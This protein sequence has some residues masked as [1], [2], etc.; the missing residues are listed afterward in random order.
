MISRSSPP[1]STMRFALITSFQFDRFHPETV[2]RLAGDSVLLGV[3]AGRV[4]DLIAANGY[5]GVVL[6]LEGMSSADGDTL[7]RVINQFARSLH[8][9]KIQPVIVA[10][11]ASDTVTYPARSVLHTADMMLVMLYDE[12]WAGSP[13]GPIASPEWARRQLGARVQAAGASRV[14][15]SLPAYGYLWNAGG[16]PGTVIGYDEAKRTALR[17]SVNLERD[18]ASQNLHATLP[19]QWDLWVSDSALVASLMSDARQLG[20]TRFA[21][22]RL[23]LE[24][25]R[26]WEI[27]E[28]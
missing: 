11:P 19:G 24:D 5:R 13:P 27:L 7:Y 12:H 2:R 20:V 28:R 22:W 23:G 1:I 18:P 14:V 3:V 9:R 26:V 10:V 15:V 25:E 8:A 6:D 17:A 4:S 21:L 16:G